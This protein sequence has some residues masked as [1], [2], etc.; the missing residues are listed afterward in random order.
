MGPILTLDSPG[1]NI[2]LSGF[3]TGTL[4][5]FVD[6]GGTVGQYDAGHRLVFTLTLQPGTDTYQFNLNSVIDNGSGVSLNNFSGVHGGNS[7]FAY[8]DVD[9]LQIEGPGDFDQALGTRF[10][11]RLQPR[12]ERRGK[13]WYCEQ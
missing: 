3:G 1:N 5:G 12:C 10:C 13:Y 6:V 4:T 2:L 8:L 9:G 7:N 11:S